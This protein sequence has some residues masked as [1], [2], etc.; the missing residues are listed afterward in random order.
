V[1][2]LVKK[3]DEA[4]DIMLFILRDFSTESKIIM[5]NSIKVIEEFNDIFDTDASK[6]STLYYD[7][8]RLDELYNIEEAVDIGFK[9]FLIKSI[10]ETKGMLDYHNYNCKSNCVICETREKME[11]ELIERKRPEI[12]KKHKK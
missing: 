6:I 4:L 3:Y 7:F 10:K 2:S 8:C 5:K 9:K 11:G 12:P 1:P